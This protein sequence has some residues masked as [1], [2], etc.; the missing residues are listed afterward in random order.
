M[1]RLAEQCAGC[2]PVR[3]RR[4]LPALGG[5][6]FLATL[7]TGEA[8]WAGPGSPESIVSDSPP[9]PAPPVQSAVPWVPPA[10]VPQPSPPPAAPVPSPRPDDTVY[11]RDGGYVRGVIVEFVPNDHVTVVTPTQEKHV[12]EWS[13]IAGVQGGPAAPT[14]AARATP[15]DGAWVHLDVRGG[16]L[17]SKRF[18][19]PSWTTACT[20]PCD[21]ELPLDAQYRWVGEGARS[22]RAFALAA[23]RGDRVTL[24][25][26]GGDADVY[27]FG[28]ALTVV[29]GVGLIAGAVMFIAGQPQCADFCLASSPANTKLETWGGVAMGVGAGLAVIG[30]LLLVRNLHSQVHSSVQ[31][32]VPRPP[33]AASSRTPTWRDAFATPKPLVAPLFT[34]SF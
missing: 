17:E 5:A 29:G 4:R 7:T 27:N 1:N 32:A 15:R 6:L 2:E 18:G 25:F 8:A 19:S 13:R 11:L 22:S 20:A 9:P 10:Y 28:L 12:V 23:K 30:T 14:E 34:R 24:T 26:S 3:S 31:N 33:P 21:V 16:T